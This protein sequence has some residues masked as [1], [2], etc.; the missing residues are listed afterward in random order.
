[1]VVV[2]VEAVEAVNTRI[3]RMTKAA[4]VA[5]EAMARHSRLDL[6]MAD[7]NLDLPGDDS[8]AEVAAVVEEVVAAAVTVG[9]QRNIADSAN[10]GP[11]L[12]CGLRPY[13]FLRLVSR[14]RDLERLVD[15][16]LVLVLV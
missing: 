11:S 2:V 5:L 3:L 1:M 16:P 8:D 9:V 6:L 4:G 10:T 14:G 12:D 15:L 13:Q 7:L